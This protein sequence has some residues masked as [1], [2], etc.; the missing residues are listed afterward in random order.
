MQ[1]MT[2]SAELKTQDATGNQQDNLQAIDA[3]E[4]NEFE[5]F[6]ELYLSDEAT[7][8]IWPRVQAGF[9]IDS[10][11]DH[12]ALLNELKWFAKHPRY[13]QRVMQ[14]ADPFL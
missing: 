5:Q 9:Q 8:S 2:A 1:V 7:Y 11:I 10:D 4:D 3:L 14:R 12:P 13:M 6:E